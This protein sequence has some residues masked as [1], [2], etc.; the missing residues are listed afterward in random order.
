MADMKR[1]YFCGKKLEQPHTYPKF[2]NGTVYGC[3]LVHNCE[4]GIKIHMKS[5]K[6]YKSKEE[7]LRRFVDIYNGED[8]KA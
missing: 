5:T 3:V 2:D 1:C 7:A 8:I 6:H 4:S